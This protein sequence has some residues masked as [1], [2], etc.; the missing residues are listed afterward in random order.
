MPEINEVAVRLK[1]MTAGHE[2]IE[3]YAHVGLTLRAAPGLVPAPGAA[4]K[5]ILTCAEAN[6]F[7]TGAR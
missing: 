5:K 7:P 6:A 1:A 4:A 3:D 2:V